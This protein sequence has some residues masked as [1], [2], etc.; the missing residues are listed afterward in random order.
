MFAGFQGV[1][2]GPSVCRV[3]RVSL[4]PGNAM[5]RSLMPGLLSS[6]DLGLCWS[7]LFLSD[8]FRVSSWGVVALV[9]EAPTHYWVALT[10]LNL[11][12]HIMGI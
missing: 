7:L 1:S 4:D 2:G 10:E 6:Y 3:H 11:S 12:H 8:C 9:K 5:V